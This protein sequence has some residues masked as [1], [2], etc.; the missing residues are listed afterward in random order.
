[1]STFFDAESAD[2]WQPPLVLRRVAAAS[3]ALGVWVMG[4][5]GMLISSAFA[6]LS[7]LFIVGLCRMTPLAVVAAPCFV[8]AALISGWHVVIT[9]VSLMRPELPAPVQIALLQPQWPRGASW[10]VALWWLGHLSMGAMCAI[11]MLIEHPPSL[12]AVLLMSIMSAAFTYAAH[13]FLMLMVTCFTKDPNWVLRAW[14]LRHVVSIGHG[15][16][17]FVVGMVR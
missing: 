13:G 17:V 8:A 10:M 9:I 11:T 12:G 4:F 2:R 16:A 15:L 5:G 3:R 14:K 6:L 7:I 1:L